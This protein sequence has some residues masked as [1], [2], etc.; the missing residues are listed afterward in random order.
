VGDT[1]R[2][3]LYKKA[4]FGDFGILKGEVYKADELIARGEIKVWQSDAGVAQ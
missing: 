3:S 2:I 1:L 4:K